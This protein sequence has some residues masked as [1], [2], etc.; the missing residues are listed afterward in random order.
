VFVPY[1][2][3]AALLNKLRNLFFSPVIGWDK[4]LNYVTAAAF[5]ICSNFNVNLNVISIRCSV[6]SAVDKSSLHKPRN[7]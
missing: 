5:Y 1:A 4:N 3:Q 7:D 6:I 2:I